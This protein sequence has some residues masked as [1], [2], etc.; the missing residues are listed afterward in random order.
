MENYFKYLELG[1]EFSWQ[2]AEIKLLLARDDALRIWL[3][4]DPITTP[5]ESLEISVK[6]REQD[7]WYD[8]GIK[9]KYTDEDSPDY[10][11]DVG[12]RQ[13]AI[14]EEKKQYLI[15]NSDYAD[16]RR[17]RDAYGLELPSNQIEVYVEWFSTDKRGY[18]DDWFLLEHRDFYDTMVDLKQ[19]EERDF[20]GVPD[21]KWRY[22][23]D[24]WAALDD[25]YDGYS[26]RDSEFYLSPE[27]TA[28]EDARAELLANNPQYRRD[29]RRRKA[30]VIGF[31]EDLLDDYVGYFEIP[32][33]SEDGW[34][35]THPSEP[36][37]EDDW[38]LMKHPEFEQAMVDLYKATDGE[39]GWK[40]KRNFA[41]VPT[42]EVYALYRQYLLER[43]GQARLDFRA[44]HPDLD[45]WLV[46]AKDL[47][48]L[49]DRGREEEEEVSPEEEHW[50]DIERERRRRWWEE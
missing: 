7:D 11:G 17:R 19:M 47:K 36:Y 28:R 35:N 15:D 13:D 46:L 9:A 40:E 49:E 4:W 18:T 29:R 30:V 33:K 8:E 27:G 24:N 34:F 3:K 32:D 48:P 21:V 45:A 5:I 12:D 42:R 26:D 41:K 20:S 2:D 22:L 10:I 38:Y 14:E 44:K 50:K 1:N 43:K 16:D 25:K 6:Y 39:H 23:W 37:Y 31:P